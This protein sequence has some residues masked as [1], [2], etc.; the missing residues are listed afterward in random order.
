MMGLKAKYILLILVF[1]FFNAFASAPPPIPKIPIPEDL[2]T[3]QSEETPSEVPSEEENVIE[4]PPEVKLNVS[5]PENEEEAFRRIKDYKMLI[6]IIPPGTS[7]ETIKKEIFGEYK[8]LVEPYLEEEEKEDNGNEEELSP[9][10]R[11]APSDEWSYKAYEE[12]KLQNEKTPP[13][14][15]WKNTPE[16]RKRTPINNKLSSISKEKVKSFIHKRKEN[17][18]KPSSRF[19]SKPQEKESSFPL[20]PLIG[21]IIVTALFVLYL[22]LFLSKRTS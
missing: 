2:Q 14:K 20:L 4:P 3:N 19:E 18:Q 10:E 5:P 16:H 9:Y 12:E 17:K 22:L 8:D 15:E 21:F 7:K 13:P 11:R 6:E 1:S